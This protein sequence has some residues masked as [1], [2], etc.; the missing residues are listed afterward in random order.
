MSLFTSI[1]TSKMVND[2]ALGAVRT[3]MAGIIPTLIAGGW[4]QQNQ[5]NDTLGSVMFL[6]ALGLSGL[7]K[8]IRGKQFK[9]ALAVVPMGY[10]PTAATIAGAASSAAY[11]APAEPVIVPQKT[12]KPIPDPK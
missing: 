1:A 11:Q 7:D 8:V 12:M 3:I 6:A 10:V 5:V 4:L 2:M 9:A